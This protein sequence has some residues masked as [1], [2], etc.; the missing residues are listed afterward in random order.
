M[1]WPAAIG[2]RLT[3]VDG[4]EVRE[5]PLPASPEAIRDPETAEPGMRVERV[6]ADGVVALRTRRQ[7]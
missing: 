3:V 7:R 4:V 5:R 6:D 1:A 2:D